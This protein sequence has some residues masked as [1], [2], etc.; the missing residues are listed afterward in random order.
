VHLREVRKE[1][2]VMDDGGMDSRGYRARLQSE[3]TWEEH[4]NFRSLAK[5]VMGTFSGDAF[6]GDDV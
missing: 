5:E 4:S 3:R 6:Q 2:L 1:Q